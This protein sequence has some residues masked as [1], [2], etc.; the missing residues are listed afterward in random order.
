[1]PLTPRHPRS[2]QSRRRDGAQ[3][4]RWGVA[5]FAQK[6]RRPGVHK[7]LG[8]ANPHCTTSTVS[9]SER[10]EGTGN[11]TSWPESPSTATRVPV[12]PSTRTGV[13]TALPS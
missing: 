11:T 4:H 2:S 8:L 6:G 9:P 3:R 5:T 1:M 7:D 13:R 12:S 10:L